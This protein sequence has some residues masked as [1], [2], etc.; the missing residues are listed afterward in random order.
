VVRDE[1]GKILHEGIGDF[2]GD[3]LVLDLFFPLRECS[4]LCRRKEEFE[5]SFRR[6]ILKWDIMEGTIQIGTTW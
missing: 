1:F 2:M 5:P 3:G 6:E 4:F